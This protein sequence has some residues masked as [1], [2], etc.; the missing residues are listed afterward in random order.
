[1]PPE[2]CGLGA[3]MGSKKLKAVVAR[4]TKGVV[5]ADKVAAQKYGLEHIKTLKVVNPHTGF[6]PIKGREEMGH[7][8]H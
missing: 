4:G 2:Q 3:V 5:I 7:Q 6:T 1:M 8:F